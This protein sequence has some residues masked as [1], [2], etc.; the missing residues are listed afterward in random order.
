MLKKVLGSIE[1][2]LELVKTDRVAIKACMGGHGIGFY[3]LSYSGEKYYANDKAMTKSEF[4]EFLGKLDNC[5]VTE[6]GVPHPALQEIC[7]T[8]TFAV[9]RTVT[10]FDEKDGAQLTAVTIRLGTKAA[11]F[12]SDYDRTIYC[13]VSLEDG[14]LFHPIYR[15]GDAEGIM[16]STAIVEH[17]DTGRKLEGTIL[18][19]F[20]QLELLVKNISA[21]LPMTPYL[22]MD[23]IPTKDGFQ[24]LEINSHGQVRNVEPFYPFNVNPYNRKVFQL[25]KTRVL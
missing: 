17:P 9:I 4:M 5:M 10:V 24:I 7:G 23:I 16:R 2:I 18:P 14:S 15:S 1:E 6:Y 8:E 21:Y 13:G 25:D 20:E 3:K 12:V 22:V 19:N 11:G